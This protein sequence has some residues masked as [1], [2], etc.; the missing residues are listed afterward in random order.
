MS[1]LTQW[2]Q[3]KI[4]AILQMTSS[5]VSFSMKK[6]EFRSKFR[7]RLF[8]RAQ[9]IISQYFVVWWFGNEQA[10]SHY[11]NRCWP[12]SMTTYGVVRLNESC[13]QMRVL[14]PYLVITCACAWWRHRME[15]FSVLQ[16][17]CAGNSLV[18]GEFPPQRLVARSV[19]VFCDLRMNKQMSKQS[20]GWW[21]ETP[22]CSL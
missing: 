4:T 22:S 15:T 1:N 7:W 14:H 19:D 17:L 21:F 12:S 20:W 16:A 10:T 18:T 8:L 3:S 11:L 13:F 6:I 2:G 5:N 9:L